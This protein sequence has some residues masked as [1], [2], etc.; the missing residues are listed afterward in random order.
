MNISRASFSYLLRAKCDRDW[1]QA[2]STFSA[3]LFSE[4]FTVSER[5][6]AALTV[7]HIEALSSM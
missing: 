3:S 1:K 5:D 7:L 6:Y 2:Q 4:V